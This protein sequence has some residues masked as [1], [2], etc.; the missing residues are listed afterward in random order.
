MA[1]QKIPD[2]DTKGLRQ[3]GLILGGILA[4]VFG[5]L[6]PWKWGWHALPNWY[7]IG[8]G[9]AIALWALLHA[10]SMRCL[11]TAWMRV[12]LVIGGVINAVILAA[13]FF[14]IVT[15]MGLFARWRGWDPLSRRF[16]RDEGTYRVRSRAAAKNHMERTY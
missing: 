16:A 14:L 5:L 12:A 6:L 2:L 11:Y 7:W 10:D 4:S 8:A 9:A 13:V 1:Y 15:P 3:F